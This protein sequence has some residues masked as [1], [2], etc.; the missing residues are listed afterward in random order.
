MR[1]SFARIVVRGTQ[2][3]AMALLVVSLVTG[4]VHA[5]P[6]G[7]RGPGPSPG[8]SPGRGPGGP[9]MGGPGGP[10]AA[11]IGGAARGPA[12]PGPGGVPA[13]GVPQQQPA[14]QAA[15]AS[16]APSPFTPAWYSQHPDA[17]QHPKPFADWR[18]S[19]VP[20]VAVVNAYFGVGGATPPNAAALTAVEWLSLGV[21][22]PPVQPGVPPASFQQLAIS[23]A[24][25]VKGVMFDAMANS[26]QPIS[27]TVDIAS[28][29]VA[30]NVGASGGL[31]FE[32]SLDE[33]MKP[34]PAVTVTTASGSQP[35]TLVLTSQP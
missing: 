13:A 31:G 25:Q 8:V 5:Q 27:G 1:K 32:S 28:R 9:S 34:A 22:T 26:V 23:K 17:W 21:F 19:P 35:G 33:L 3:V 11:G 20:P 7:R 24:G 15:R 29:K 2:V 12:M 18:S 4:D 30:W 6:G 14:A 16:A 10:G